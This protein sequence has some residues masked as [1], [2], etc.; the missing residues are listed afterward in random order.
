M[1]KEWIPFEIF[2]GWWE[3]PGNRRDD[4]GEGSAEV[5]TVNNAVI[6]GRSSKGSE[7]N[8]SNIPASAGASFEIPVFPML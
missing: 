5:F 2:G 6:T 8:L 4:S 7:D 1:L 3:V